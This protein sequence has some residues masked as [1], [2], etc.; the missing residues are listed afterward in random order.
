[1]AVEYTREGSVG[2]ITL[3]NPPANSYDLLF[4]EELSECGAP[5]QRTP[6]PGCDPAQRQREVLLRR[7]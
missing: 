4:M 3:D 1:M 5:R 6:G 7:G 2:Y